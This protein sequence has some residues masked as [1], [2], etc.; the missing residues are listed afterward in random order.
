[1][2]VR[3]RSGSGIGRY[4]FESET[5][6][7]IASTKLFGLVPAL[8]VWDDALAATLKTDTTVAIERRERTRL[9][10]WHFIFICS[11]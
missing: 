11:P 9:L 8:G 1:M 4:R 10:E 5:S 2:S 6:E 3:Y 7:N